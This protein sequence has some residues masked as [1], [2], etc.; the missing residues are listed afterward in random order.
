[1]IIE[2][3]CPC[4]PLFLAN[5]SSCSYHI[6]LTISSVNSGLWSHHTSDN[7]DCWRRI[8]EFFTVVL[9]IS[10]NPGSVWWSGLCSDSSSIL[11]VVKVLCPSLPLLFS[12]N[13]AHVSGTISSTDG[14]S[15]SH[16]LVIYNGDS[17]WRVLEFF[18]IVSGI[19][20]QVVKSVHLLWSIHPYTLVHMFHSAHSLSKFYF[21]VEFNGA[22][23][24][25][26]SH[27][28]K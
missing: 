4:L 8:L 26:K 14:S 25:Q 24:A 3:L 21:F 20:L 19:S 1:L 15:W 17:R 22:S 16:C 27:Y 28:S 7:C 6:W 9:G 18:S 10:L 13:L 5:K 23:I 2:V 12:I 11:L